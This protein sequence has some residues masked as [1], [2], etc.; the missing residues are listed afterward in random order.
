MM[1]NKKPS[2]RRTKIVSL[3]LALLMAGSVTAAGIF[4]RSQPNLLTV[5]AD[6]AVSMTTDDGKF[7]YI[8]TNEGAVIIG[9]AAEPTG[10][11]VIPD[12]VG[13]SPVT[14]I[15]DSAFENCA[16]ITSVQLP[17]TVH[18]IGARAFADCGNLTEV[19][20][21]NPVAEVAEDAFEGIGTNAQ[22]EEQELHTIIVE[23]IQPKTAAASSEEPL[24]D[25]LMEDLV[26]LLYEAMMNDAESVDVSY[27]R[28]SDTE[29][30]LSTVM[31]KLK[32]THMLEYYAVEP[33]IASMAV[34]DSVIKT[35]HLSYLDCDYAPTARERVDMM[36]PIVNSVVNQARNL[37][38]YEKIFFV[39]DY[40]VLNYSYD[41]SLSKHSAFEILTGGKGVCSSYYRAFDLFMH[42]LDIPCGYA[43]G[44]I[45]DGNG[46][47]MAHIWNMVKLDGEWYH[48]DVTWDDHNSINHIT[49]KEYASYNNILNNDDEITDSHGA[50]WTGQYSSTS[51]LYSNM[52]RDMSGMC[53]RYHEKW[54]AF[55]NTMPRRI[56]YF[57]KY[58]GNEQ[59][60]A[61]PKTYQ[62][63]YDDVFCY[64]DDSNIQLY[65]PDSDHI[66][67]LYTLSEAEQAYTVVPANPVRISSISIDDDGIVTY[68]CSAYQYTTTYEYVTLDGETNINLQ[69]FLAQIRNFTSQLDALPDSITNSSVAARAVSVLSIYDNF[70]SL[71]QSNIDSARLAKIEAIRA[72]L[73]QFTDI[74]AVSITLSQSALEMTERDTCVLEATVSPANSTDMPVW[75]SSDTSV[76][77]VKNGEITAIGEGSAV[78]TA[79]AGDQSAACTVTVKKRILPAAEI[80]LSQ[81]TLTMT[82]GNVVKLT[83]EVN[84]ADTTDTLSWTSS[85][86][87][88]A[89]V[90]NGKIKALSPGVV[91]I[92]AAAGDQSATCTVTVNQYLIPIQSM[93]LKDSTKTVTKGQGNILFAQVTP[94][95]FNDTI[96][97]TSS[98]PSIV[99]VRNS[100]TYHTEGIIEGLRTGTAV[101]TAQIG[102]FSDSCTV[103]VVQPATGITLSA[104]N[105]KLEEGT[106]GTVAATLQ[107]EDCT[108]TIT[109]SSGD[110]SVVTVS[111]TGVITAVSP[112]SV[113]VT[114]T[115]GNKTVNCYVTVTPAPTGVTISYDEISIKEGFTTRLSASVVPST[116]ITPITWSTSDASIAAVDNKGQVTAVAPGIATIY[117]TAGSVRAACVVTVTERT[118]RKPATAVTLSKTALTL[119][120]NDVSALTAALTPSDS[121]DA[122]VWTS[123]DHSVATVSQGSITA[124]APGTA[125]I[126]AT[127][128][129]VSATCTVTVTDSSQIPDPPQ[130]TG[131][132]FDTNEVS[133][134]V[135]STFT[136]G[137]IFTPSGSAGELTWTSFN[138][139]VADVDSQGNIT[140]VAAGSAVITAVL[141]NGESASI[142]V[143]VTPEPTQA[144]SIALNL[145]D[146]SLFVGTHVAPKVFCYPKGSERTVT[147]TSSKPNIASVDS[148]G[149]I[150]AVAKGKAVIIAKLD[151]GVSAAVNVTVTAPS[152]A[153]TSITPKKST[154]GLVMT[155]T[156]MNPT[157]TLTA[158]VKGGTTGKMWYSDDID[159][160]T[161]T[162]AGKVTAV[163][164]GTANVYCR[165]AD[166]SV[167]EPCEITVGT[168]L[169]DSDNVRGGMVYVNDKESCSLRMDTTADHGAV[170]WKSS[171]ANIASVDS[172][173]NVTARKKGTVTITATAADKT[174]DTIKLV[175]VAPSA[176]I[177]LKA[178]A[179]SMYMGKTVTL[180]ASLTTKN[181]NDPI[182]W[183]S[184]DPNI[185]TVTAKGVVKGIRQGETTITATTFNGQSVTA[186]VIVRT[187]AKKIEMDDLPPA[188][189]VGDIK[190][191]YA[192]ITDPVACNDTITWS[193]SNKS[194]A[195][196]VGTK[197]HGITAEIQALKSGT[198]TITA[199][200]GSGKRA[201]YKIKVVSVPVSQLQLNKTS[202]RVGVK[203]SV[204]LTAKQVAPKG[205]N[206]VI[207]WESYDP[208]IAKVDANGKVT[209]VSPGE[210]TIIAYPV[211]GGE[212]VTV[213]AT[214]TVTA[215]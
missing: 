36:T 97:W 88:I 81:S 31:N 101:I 9:Y 177:T 95:N 73:G 209:G 106:T 195:K 165:T 51:T 155:H 5:R 112:G 207:I 25:A 58:G 113:N 82:E 119:A 49:N 179:A 60:V 121:T 11:I 136:P 22:T 92:T 174:K 57:D 102:G 15:G 52:K 120:V 108:D 100:P 32:E 62:W 147:W 142:T 140:A 78:I 83:A 128:G 76:A 130:A 63:I 3:A 14:A 48:V 72:N 161:V 202:A 146:I 2:A 8:L 26:E 190:Q 139:A 137:I 114:A 45:P 107:P 116:C 183:S 30:M 143:T 37:T 90:T 42:Y 154:L 151:N 158:T 162:N 172:S 178:N 99:S 149:T 200:T 43:S 21:S 180:K 18:R 196:V 188:L 89:T 105:M 66:G 148:S 64:G 69:E 103:T 170:T 40:L 54:Y 206:D 117:A 193:T 187:P 191:F 80:T 20:L 126:T 24:S 160:V 56:V 12:V 213:A 156:K 145:K 197:D 87:T 125:T 144:A 159:V 127:A 74:P 86:D 28:I 118:D 157:A 124:I 175:V 7:L 201:S 205:A 53:H 33:R 104:Y 19:H 194:I 16:G 23:P 153:T 123:S 111:E 167:S 109:W 176:G 96:T 34:Q 182:F 1:K 166:G 198:V 169:I 210:T 27:Y 150:T 35:V 122:V 79:V 181:S 203:K 138:R 132:S 163:G 41:S 199:K 38:D 71:Q 84:P 110:T 46:S 93:T 39:H 115:A 75:T 192:L 13:E 141:F 135:G 4:L 65:W 212:A 189:M 173:G 91:I 59:I 29:Y 134:A 171:N 168:F 61:Y 17:D 184:S 211:Y 77:T 70:T 164:R 47:K 131:V 208:T 85:D 204:T 44:F 68:Q 129:S 50:D 186:T 215:K 98:D 152:K 185:A 55:Y 67:T 10:D 6:S 214:I 94:S 133:L